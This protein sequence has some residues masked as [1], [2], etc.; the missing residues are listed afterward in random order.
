MRAVK[1]PSKPRRR[2]AQV[3]ESEVAKEVFRKKHPVYT[4]SELKPPALLATLPS[5]AVACS[6]TKRGADLRRSD[7][8][9]IA[10]VSIERQDP[11]MA[12]S[13]TKLLVRVRSPSRQT[14]I[15]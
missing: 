2:L 13:Q 10:Y 12:Y 11:C 3:S 9:T 1:P 8:V 7:L 6:A 15:M 4:C 5:S 14:W